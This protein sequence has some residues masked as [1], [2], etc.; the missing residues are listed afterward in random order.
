MDDTWSSKWFKGKFG[1]FL[2]KQ[3]RRKKKTSFSICNNYPSRLYQRPCTQYPFCPKLHQ[4]RLACTNTINESGKLT[5][6]T[7]YRVI[8]F[9]SSRPNW[10][11]PTPSPA[12]V[13]CSSPLLGPRG[14]DT[15]ACGGRSGG[16][17]IRR[18]DRHNATLC[19]L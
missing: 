1:S 13:C 8:G 16:T 2:D 7:D 6:Y 10:V 18:R 9:L 14:V 4:S 15:L 11:P 17:K 19:L 3:I 5:E 12:R